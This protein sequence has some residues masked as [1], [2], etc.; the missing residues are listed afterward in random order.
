VLRIAGKGSGATGWVVSLP[1]TGE[2]KGTLKKL[3][4]ATFPV[5]AIIADSQKGQ[6]KT[7]HLRRLSTPS[8]LWTPRTEWRTLSVNTP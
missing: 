7:P 8:P 5:Q 1:Q 6:K 2:S 4:F 3:V